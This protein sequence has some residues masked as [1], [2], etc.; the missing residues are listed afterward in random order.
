MNL[1]G[2]SGDEHSGAGDVCLAAAREQPPKRLVHAAAFGE[3]SE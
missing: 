1:P 3:G 2:Q